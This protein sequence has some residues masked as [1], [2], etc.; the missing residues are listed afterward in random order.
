M[1][2]HEQTKTVESIAFWHLLHDMVNH[3]G[4]VLFAF[5]AEGGL[6]AMVEEDLAVVT[7]EHGS[8]PVEESREDGDVCIDV[9]ALE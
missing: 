6:D 2:L 4:P 8:D 9:P 7:T 1:H 5:C 3:W